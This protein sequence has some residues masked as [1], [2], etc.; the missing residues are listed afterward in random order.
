KRS[1]KTLVAYSPC[2]S[3][4]CS[5]VSLRRKLVRWSGRK[6]YAARNSAVRADLPRHRVLSP[7][8]RPASISSAT[9]AQVHAQRPCDQVYF[10]LLVAT[11]RLVKQV[12][13]PPRWS[14][15]PSRLHQSS[16][17]SSRWR[18]RPLIGWPP[19][20]PPPRARRPAR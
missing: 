14:S 16:T 11:P 18:R 13:T 20:H 4:S 10:S 9:S 1:A 15:A 17:S 7:V 8:S 6:A 3:A 12:R 2:S 5:P 19:A